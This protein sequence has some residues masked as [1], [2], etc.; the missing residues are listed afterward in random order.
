MLSWILTHDWDITL[1]NI[2]NQCAYNKFSEWFRSHH[3]Q[4]PNRIITMYNYMAK[5][6]LLSVITKLFWNDSHW[7]WRIG[8]TLTV[9]WSGVHN[10]LPLVENYLFGNCILMCSMCAS[11]YIL[12]HLCLG[13]ALKR[14]IVTQYC[15]WP[16]YI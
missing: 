16:F 11:Q 9:E 6:T 1:F 7:Q 3:L 12:W 8:H 10:R 5:I 15:I 14:L 13:S 4:A 2:E